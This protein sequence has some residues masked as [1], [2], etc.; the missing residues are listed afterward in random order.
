[1]PSS[2]SAYAALDSYNVTVRAGLHPNA[3]QFLA[4]V[5]NIPTREQRL[6]ASVDQDGFAK[7]DQNGHK[8]TP[9]QVLDGAL[10]V[11]SELILADIQQR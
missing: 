3:N 7:R 10:E 1:M 2:F 8:C 4:E 11:V 6:S 9:E 5:P